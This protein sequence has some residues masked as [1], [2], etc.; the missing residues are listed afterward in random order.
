M[1]E[2]FSVIFFQFVKDNSH[3]FPYPVRILVIQKKIIMIITLCGGN[4]DRIQFLDLLFIHPLEIDL[5]R[6]FLF[7]NAIP[8][9]HEVFTRIRLQNDRPFFASITDNTSIRNPI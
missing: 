6:Q 8:C 5:F 4:V 3:Q 2:L 7:D 9:F 1:R